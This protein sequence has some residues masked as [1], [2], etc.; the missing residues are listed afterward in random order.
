MR[1][2]VTRDVH[3]ANAGGQPLR[4]PEPRYAG[5][6]RFHE[7]GTTGLAGM[8]F[9]LATESEEI[10]TTFRPSP[11]TPRMTWMTRMM[12]IVLRLTAMNIEAGPPLSKAAAWRIAEARLPAA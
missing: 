7:E 2:L 10:D 3:R 6:E 12:P 1:Y 5:M 11:P 9:L 8:V 4:H